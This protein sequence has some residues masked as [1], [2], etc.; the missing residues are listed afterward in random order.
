MMWILILTLEK[1]RLGVIPETARIRKKL[2]L[3]ET[4]IGYQG[5]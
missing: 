1:M 2:I 5:S 3:A 4:S